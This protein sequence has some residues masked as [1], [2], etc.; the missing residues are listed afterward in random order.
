M[1]VRQD[2][3][4]VLRMAKHHMRQRPDV[5]ASIALYRAGRSSSLPRVAALLDSLLPLDERTSTDVMTIDKL[6]IRPEVE[7]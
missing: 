3:E 1:P 4:M 5:G 6:S 7:A 2:V